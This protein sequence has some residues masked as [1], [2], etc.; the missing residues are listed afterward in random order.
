MSRIW[1]VA[2]H[3][4]I[5]SIRLKSAVLFILINLAIIFILPFTFTGDGITLKSRIQG[6]LD[7][8]I[9]STAFLLS[10]MTVFPACSSLANEIRLKQIFM[11]ASKPVPRWQ[12]FAGKWLGIS[13]LNAALLLASGLSIWALTWFYL[14]NRPTYPDDA[15]AVKYDVLTVRYG[16]KMDQP[17]FT[18]QVE[19]KLRRLREEGRLDNLSLTGRG[20][21]RNEIEEDLKKS[22]RTV[23]P[24]Q[25]KDFA[26]S[27]LLVDRQEPGQLY[28]RFKPLAPS[29]VD[30]ILFRARWQAGDRDDVNTLTAV[31]EK[32]FVVD[33]FHSEPIPAAAVNRDGVLHLRIQNIDQKESILFEGGDGFEVLYDI[34][35]FHWNLARAL[36]IVWCRL[37]FLAV[38]GLT[39]STFLSFPVACMVAFVVMFVASGSGFLSEAVQWFEPKL[40]AGLGEVILK[41]TLLWTVRSVLWLIPDFS[42]F[43]PAGTVV[44]GRVVP[45]L[46][47]IQS[48]VALVLFKGL[49][50]GAI[51]SVIFMRR[52]LGLPTS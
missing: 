39:A 40:N 24:G 8:S 7:L 5:E 18:A 51:G 16:A 2:R 3:T 49:A 13:M 4:I 21:L 1:A 52:Q 28:M 48:L 45:L 44:A 19:E 11:I 41:S 35:T 12:F 42:L 17:D 9:S 38:L 32:D 15:N 47:V 29:G 25:Y 43:D 20:N 34:G 31:Q 46:W 30:G 22:W 26:F 37:V 23:G 6:F 27:G 36:F 50:V 14:R 10:L 33:R